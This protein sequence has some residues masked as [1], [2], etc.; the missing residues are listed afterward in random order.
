MIQTAD[1][2]AT[3]IDENTTEPS[4]TENAVATADDTTS[5]LPALEILTAEIQS[6]FVKMAENIIEIGKRL[7]KAKELVPHG[8]W[9]NWL[10]ENFS[11]SQMTANNFMRVAERFGKIKI[12]FNFRPT[13]LIAMLAL[14]AG[15]EEK[16][17]AEKSAAGTPIEN[18]SVR[19]LKTEIKEWKDA[20]QI[21]DVEIVDDSEV[22]FVDAE[23]IDDD[24]VDDSQFEV[25]DVEIIDDDS[26]NEI[27]DVTPN[28]NS[29]LD[30][31]FHLA[32]I[33]L[34]I[35]SNAMIDYVNKLSNADF[36]QTIKTLELIIVRFKTNRN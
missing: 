26:E 15:D 14:P 28:V 10:E 25:A 32:E 12:D 13:Q 24:S 21:S 34:T 9:Q 16:F 7:I 3:P 4:T 33:V 20:A 29:A 30:D 8:E 35:N 23:I 17:I 1:K 18:L 2:M 22:E 5:T 6:Y 31:F 36:N 11:L 27:I 19:K